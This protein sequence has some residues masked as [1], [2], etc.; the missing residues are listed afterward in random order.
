MKKKGDELRGCVNMMSRMNVRNGPEMFSQRVTLSHLCPVFGR[1]TVVPIFRGLIGHSDQFTSMR[2]RLRG[3]L[4]LAGFDTR[5]IKRTLARTRGS[6]GFTPNYCLSTVAL[7][8][9]FQLVIC[10]K[11]FLQLLISHFIIAGFTIRITVIFWLQQQLADDLLSF[12]L[13]GLCV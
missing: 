6:R 10:S 4:K 12:L 7:F 13:R 3:F 9:Q 1:R 5:L 8:E 11:Q 2:A